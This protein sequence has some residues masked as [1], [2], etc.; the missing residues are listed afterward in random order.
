MAT[1]TSQSNRSLGQKFLEAEDNWNLEQLY[2]D[3]TTAKQFHKNSEKQKLTKTEKTVLRGLLCGSSP[4]EI[5]TALHRNCS[6][7]RVDLS[8]GL[9]R[10]IEVI[11][12]KSLHHWKD[13]SVFLEAAE[14]KL[15]IHL[16][17]E[18]IPT[19]EA[20]NIAQKIAENHPQQPLTTSTPLT[21]PSPVKPQKIDWIEAIDVS[22]FYGRETE[23]TTL[24]Q[25]I[26]DDRCRVVAISGIQGIGKTSI[27]SKLAGQIQNDFEYIIWRNLDHAPPFTHLLTDLIQFFSKSSTPDNPEEYLISQLFKKLVQSRVSTSNFNQSVIIADGIRTLIKFLEK[28]RCLIILDHWES[29]FQPNT[30]VGHYKEGYQPYGDFLNKI[31]QLIHQSCLLITSS[32]TPRTISRLTGKNQAVCYLK[33]KGLKPQNAQKILK[34]EGIV[35]EENLE[36]LVSEYHGNP[37]AL[38][39]IGKTIQ[40]VFAGNTTEFINYPAFFGEFGDRLSC[41]FQRLS[42]TEK[43]LLYKIAGSTDCITLTQLCDPSQSCDYSELIQV[44]DS[45]EKRSLISIKIELD[46]CYYSINPLINYYLQE[47]LPSIS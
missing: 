17:N 26:I 44:L 36:Q 47:V 37:L 5:A 21:T 15:E 34:H 10:Y 20:V 41:Q 14:Y 30:L 13:V 22:T 35:E 28:H 39:T 45:L 12:Q 2:S 3:L 32:E 42:K 46:Q 25:W 8:R 31:G 4:S 38:Q 18:E 9:Y 23:L 11:T 1:S 27:A 7:L 33:V 24:K 40:T 16:N 19:S 43:K 6:G 29:L